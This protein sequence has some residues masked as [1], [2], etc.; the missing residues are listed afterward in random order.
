MGLQAKHY[1]I[2]KTNNYENQAIFSTYNNELPS[3]QSR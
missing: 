3:L 1:N 2:F